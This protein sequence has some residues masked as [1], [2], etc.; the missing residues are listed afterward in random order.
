MQ[1]LKK[2]II[3]EIVFATILG[4]VA[5]IL[6][7]T[8]LKDYYLPVFWILFS[9][10]S[11]FTAL[12]HYSVLQV[13]NKELTKFSSKFMMFAGIKMIIYLIIIVIYVF[14]FPEKAKFFLISFFILYML[15]TVFEVILIIKHLKKH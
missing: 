11:L 9:V 10:I 6:F 14:S 1:A 2:F 12:F 13:G 5:Y 4:L 7:Q 3:R 8:I 15:Y